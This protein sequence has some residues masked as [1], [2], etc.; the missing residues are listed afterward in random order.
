MAVKR[1]R[2]PTRRVKSLPARAMTG[3]REKKVKGGYRG[4]YQLR[5]DE[6]RNLVK[7]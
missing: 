2:K 4:K 3:A 6:G 5:L 1:G 7:P